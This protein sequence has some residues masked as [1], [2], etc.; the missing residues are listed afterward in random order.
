[1]PDNG[2]NVHGKNLRAP[3]QAAHQKS[4]QWLKEMLQHAI[5]SKAKAN[6]QLMKVKRSFIGLTLRPSRTVSQQHFYLQIARL[7][8]SAAFSLSLLGAVVV[9]RHDL[10]D[11]S[12]RVEL[13][14]LP[15]PL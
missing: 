3:E 4:L 11:G 9:S 7:R 1:M 5:P 10:V 12:V 2:W 8:N 14:S 6:Q 13:L 15:L